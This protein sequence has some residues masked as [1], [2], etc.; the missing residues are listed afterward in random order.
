MIN[1]IDKRRNQGTMPKKQG[2]LQTIR[3]SVSYNSNKSTEHGKL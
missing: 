1:K 2:K 3:F